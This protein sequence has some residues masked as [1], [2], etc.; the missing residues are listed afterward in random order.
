MPS[1]TQNQRCFHNPA[2]HCL[3]PPPPTFPFLIK[4][5]LSCFTFY[6]RV[7]TGCG[8]ECRR[9]IIRFGCGKRNTC[10][11]I[12]RIELQCGGLQPNNSWHTQFI[13]RCRYICFSHFH[14]YNCCKYAMRME[15]RH[16]TRTF[17]LAL[18]AVSFC[19]FCL[20]RVAVPGCRCFL[21]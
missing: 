10:P 12:R 1:C 8:G 14:R 6:R 2:R 20:A 15:R 9:N 7:H 16:A 4:Y 21:R 5:P 17:P 19:C 11:A 18:F 3:L 13:H